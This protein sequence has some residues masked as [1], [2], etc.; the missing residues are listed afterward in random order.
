LKNAI[1]YKKDK[2]KDT[3]LKIEQHEPTKHRGWILEQHEPTKHRGWILEQHEPTKHRG[4]I[5]RQCKLF[6]LH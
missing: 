4:W 6:M 2:E 5:L 1:Q 3:K